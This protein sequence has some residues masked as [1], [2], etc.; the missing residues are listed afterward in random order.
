MYGRISSLK[1]SIP[2]ECD[3]RMRRLNERVLAAFVDFEAV[4]IS[5]DY[6]VAKVCDLLGIVPYSPHKLLLIALTL[7]RDS[8]HTNLSDIADCQLST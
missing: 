8:V 6:S 5:Q 2:L 3:Y 4:S 7:F 1:N